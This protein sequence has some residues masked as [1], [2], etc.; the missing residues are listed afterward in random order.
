M[1]LIIYAIVALYT[2]FQSS[3]YFYST[4][5]YEDKEADSRAL[6]TTMLACA[7]L[8]CLF[9]MID[10][11][12]S[13]NRTI[14]D[15]IVLVLILLIIWFLSNRKRIVSG[16]EYL[17]QNI[18]GGRITKLCP[19]CGE[20]IL[21]SAI[22]CRY[23]GSNLVEVEP[24][25]AAGVVGTDNKINQNDLVINNGEEPNQPGTIIR[26]QKRC[27]NCGEMILAISAMCPNCGQDLK[28][29]GHTK[30]PYPELSAS[31]HSIKNNEIKISEWEEIYQ[32]E[33]YGKNTKVCPYCGETILA[34]AVR[35]RYCDQDLTEPEQAPPPD[36]GEPVLMK[37]QA[38][39][40]LDMDNPGLAA[41]PEPVPVDEADRRASFWVIG[42]LV[43]AVVVAGL[44]YFLT[45]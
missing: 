44:L 40:I 1:R 26:E 28:E 21:A 33:A 38:D 9:W 41:D 37:N 4:H 20:T 17:Y 3:E 35:C 30:I 6:N 43:V 36:P 18:A 29:P 5:K 2:F 39:I 32:R 7:L 12:S 24:E 23:C 14:V 25:S 15:S 16:K 22:K 8:Y 31:L 11:V 27:P 45:R 34:I 13:A 10:Q 19:Q 42:T